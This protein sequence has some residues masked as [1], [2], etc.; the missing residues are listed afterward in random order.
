MDW[1]NYDYEY[2]YDS[3]DEGAR[4]AH[5]A[6]AFAILSVIAM[7]AVVF[8]AML[9]VLWVLY[10]IKSGFDRRRSKKVIR[11]QWWLQHYTEYGVSSVKE[12][13]TPEAEETFNS[14]H[15]ALWKEYKKN[16]P[17]PTIIIWGRRIVIAATC[18]S[19]AMVV[20]FGA[21]RSMAQKKV[22]SLETNVNKELHE[23]SRKE[24]LADQ[25]HRLDYS[26]KDMIHAQVTVGQGSEV[27][28]ED[29][30][31]IPITV[32]LANGSTEDMDGML[33][34]M[35]MKQGEAA[36]EMLSYIGEIRLFEDGPEQ[37]D[38]GGYYYLQ[39]MVQPDI[40]N[41]QSKAGGIKE[42]NEPSL[43]LNLEIAD[44]PEAGKNAIE[45]S[46]KV[47][48]F[49]DAGSGSFG[50]LDGYIGIQVADPSVS[51]RL[52]YSVE[53]HEYSFLLP[54]IG[55]ETAAPDSGAASGGE[56]AQ[57]TVSASSA[58]IRSG[59]GKEH[60]VITSAANGAVLDLTGNEEN[61]WAEVYL[62]ETLNNTGWISRSLVE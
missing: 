25:D 14:L 32:R 56:L 38:G 46:H 4:T 20:M 34:I 43:Q 23:Y 22:V 9:P 60:Q 5:M 49:L 31:G 17:P 35:E 1:F 12:A 18:L 2:D 44:G 61:G 53:G 33:R 50:V 45:G 8:I 57:V 13:M 39:V 26:A 37:A 6:V 42:T 3:M 19:I 62:D 58:N 40:A 27:S 51:Y 28:M 36:K 16:N 24:Y 15:K 48:K 10:L 54:A 7:A 30:A 47:S 59:P 11:A 21:D 41:N 55:T 29:Y 52:S